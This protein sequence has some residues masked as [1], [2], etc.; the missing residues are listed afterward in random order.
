MKVIV[1][2]QEVTIGDVVGFKSDIEQSGVIVEIKQSYSGKALVLENKH[3][4]HGYYIG[5]DTITT[6][7][8]RDCWLEG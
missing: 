2:G 1:D 4:F 6:Q 8:A 7:L 3:G 5:G